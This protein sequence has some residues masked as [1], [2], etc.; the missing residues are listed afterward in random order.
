MQDN[1]NYGHFFDIEMQSSRAQISLPGDMTDKIDV[2]LDGPR[3][4]DKAPK[5]PVTDIIDNDGNVKHINV[6]RPS[7]QDLG[8]G[9]SQSL[10]L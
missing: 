3:Q 8:G 1:M 5:M 2:H 10:R 6:I 7:K 9:S 4:I